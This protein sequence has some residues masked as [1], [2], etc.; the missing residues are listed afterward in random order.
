ME[1]LTSAQMADDVRNGPLSP[2]GRDRILQLLERD[3]E[4]PSEG[5]IA[6]LADELTKAETEAAQEVAASAEK[7]SALKAQ[8]DADPAAQAALAELDAEF[9]KIDKEAAEQIDTAAEEL[10]ATLAGVAEDIADVK[11][12]AVG[13]VEGEAQKG[14]LNRI[15][16]S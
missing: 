1:I 9:A 7:L 14:L 6:A 10:Q 16:Q 3:G 15:K 12:Q 8:V 4:T 5:T 11:K 2:E 13:A